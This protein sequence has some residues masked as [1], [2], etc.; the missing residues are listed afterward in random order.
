[1]CG[2]K[3]FPDLK[4]KEYLTKIPISVT[5]LEER[6]LFLME[7]FIPVQTSV[8]IFIKFTVFLLNLVP[9]EKF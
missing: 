6:E 3:T 5:E 9:T 4:Q 8:V 7:N 1:M 2:L